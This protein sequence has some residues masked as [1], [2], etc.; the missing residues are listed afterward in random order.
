MA[1]QINPFHTL[2]FFDGEYEL[3]FEVTGYFK[4]DV[5]VDINEK[6]R[7]IKVKGSRYCRR[8]NTRVISFFSKSFYVDKVVNINKIRTYVSAGIFVLVAPQQSNQSN[9][10]FSYF[11]IVDTGLL[12]SDDSLNLSSRIVKSSITLDNQTEE[13][14]L[15]LHFPRSY[16][17]GLKVSFNLAERSV[18]IEGKRRESLKHSFIENGYKTIECSDHS[19]SELLIK[20][21]KI[22][23]TVK[24]FNKKFEIDFS[25]D[26]EGASYYVSSGVLVMTF[27]VVDNYEPIWLCEEKST[28]EF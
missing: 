28:I 13:Y 27:P 17:A 26:I 3:S 7:F 6:T 14:N 23:D 11:P 4:K 18:Q 9:D 19:G 25:L 12:T 15:E 21:S 16:L 2:K 24:F 10:E 20:Q 8:D 1:K 5:K 22:K